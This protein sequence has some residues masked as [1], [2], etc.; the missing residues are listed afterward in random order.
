MSAADIDKLASLGGEARQ[1]VTSA[2]EA[3]E[4]WRD[5]IFSAN[6]RCLTKVLDQMTA[7][8]HAMGW[9]DHAAIAARE[10]LLKASKM[11]THMIDQV[12]DAWERRLKSQGGVAEA[13]RFQT[14][15]FS[16]PPFADPVSEMLRL[17]EMTLVPFKLWI[18]VAEA[19]QRNWAIAMSGSRELQPPPPTRKAA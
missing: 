9:P 7:A 1:A 10:Y 15:A 12:M 18:Q 6:D 2:F 5:E 17:G 16:G 13:M 8:H 14:P 11:Q 19:W 4:Q 3:L